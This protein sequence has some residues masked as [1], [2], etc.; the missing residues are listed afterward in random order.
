MIKLKKSKEIKIGSRVEHISHGFG[1]VTRYDRDTDDRIFVKFDIKPKGWDK[2]L[3][4]SVNCL[5]L[6]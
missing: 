3:C 4:V 2:E 1:I 5:K 6:S